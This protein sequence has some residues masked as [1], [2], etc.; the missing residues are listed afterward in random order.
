MSDDSSFKYQIFSVDYSKKKSWNAAREDCLSRGA[1]LIS[2]HNVEE[3][4]FIA[5]YTKDKTQWIGLTQEPMSG[6]ALSVTPYTFPTPL[7]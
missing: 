7:H 3:E 6:G 5:T 2:I 4:L 1:D